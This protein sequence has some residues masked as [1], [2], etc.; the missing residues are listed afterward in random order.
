M[1]YE[2]DIQGARWDG[3]RRN[4]PNNYLPPRRRIQRMMPKRL[5]FGIRTQL[6]FIVLIAALLSTIATLYIANSAI[7]NYVISQT[8]QRESLNLQVAWLVLH[9]EFGDNVSIDVNGNLVADSP[10]AANG[11]GIVGNSGINALLPYSLDKD[12]DFV[13]EVHHFVGGV[14]AVYQCA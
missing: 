3:G 7:Q 9:T 1:R 10:L 6:T 14:V 4:Q 2:S 11:S 5:R 8:E 12:V 13:D